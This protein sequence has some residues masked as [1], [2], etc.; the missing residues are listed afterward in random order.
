[1]NDKWTIYTSDDCPWCTKVLK[2]IKAHTIQP[3][4]WIRN[5]TRIEEAREVWKM[6]GF[7]TVPQVYFNGKHIGGYED[8]EDFIKKHKG[9][10]F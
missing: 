9:E 3:T 5:I 1:M 7:K 10:L 4:L 2:M 6:S 8:T